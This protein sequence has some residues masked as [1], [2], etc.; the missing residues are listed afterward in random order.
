MTAEHGPQSTAARAAD[1]ATSC[2]KQLLQMLKDAL[3][4]VLSMP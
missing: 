2:G 3:E 1:T 4:E